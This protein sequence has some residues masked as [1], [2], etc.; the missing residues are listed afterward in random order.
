M[1]DQYESISN[2]DLM[3]LWL[4]NQLDTKQRAVFEKRCLED[5]EFAEMVQCAN[6]TSVIADTA[7]DFDIPNWDKD[8]SFNFDKYKAAKQ[9][10]W[11]WQGLPISSIACSALAILMVL[12]DFN[13]ESK[14]GRF[15][16][17]FGSEVPQETIDKLVDQKLNEKLLAQQETNQAMFAQYLQTLQKQQAENSTQLTQYLLTSNR[18]ERREDFAELIKYI[19]DQRRDDQL[20]YANQLKDFQQELSFQVGPRPNYTSPNGPGFDATQ[21]NDE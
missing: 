7:G 4:D 11:Q 6:Q 17:G 21:L 19:N 14:D 9:A 8:N 20:F 18:Q 16:F 5:N 1:S 3:A 2:E 13:I 12:T 15:S 10:W